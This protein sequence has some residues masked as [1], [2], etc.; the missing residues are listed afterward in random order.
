MSKKSTTVKAPKNAKATKPAKATKAKA[1]TIAAPATKA[2][3]AMG[4]LDAAARVLK[5]SGEPMRVKAIAETIFA[6][7]Y[8]KS[9]GKTPAATI[10]A[11]MIREIARKN[12]DSRFKKTDRGLFAFNG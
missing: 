12:G 4:G 8:W 9:G 3:K 10:Y 6:K 11:A 1:A 7:G 2:D 5:E